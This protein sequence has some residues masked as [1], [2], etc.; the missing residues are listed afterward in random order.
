MKG[1]TGILLCGGKSSRMGTDKALLKIQHQHMVSYPLQVMQQRCSEILI[2]ANDSRLDF[3]DYPVICDEITGIGPIGGLYTCLKQSTND[4]NLVLACD[5]PLITG[6]VLEKM[7]Q[8]VQ[9]YDAVVPLVDQRAEPLYALY[10]KRILT[11]IK[12]SLDQK[13]YAMQKMLS[14]A[15]VYY[16]TVEP[17]HELELFNVNTPSEILNYGQLARNI[18][19]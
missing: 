4:L 9:E 12:H 19:R 6:G 13:T 11:K 10:H 18:I 7:L 5:M 2:S 8:I 14:Q 1:L 3:L 15:D 17:D 16:M